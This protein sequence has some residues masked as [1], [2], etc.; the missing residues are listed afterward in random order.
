[1]SNDS[2][3]FNG[4]CYADLTQ[5]QEQL[6]MMAELLE[7]YGHADA[8]AATRQ[9]LAFL[10]TAEALSGVPF[11]SGPSLR[12]V[13]SAAEN[14]WSGDWGRDSVDEAAQEWRA[15]KPATAPEIP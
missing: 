11:E 6:E 12:A 2:H 8:A 15:A 10:Q 3:R 14:V 7:E 9:V 4:L 1:M 13:W 5:R